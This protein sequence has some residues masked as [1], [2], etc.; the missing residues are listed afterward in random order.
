MVLSGQPVTRYKFTGVEIPAWPRL[1][2]EQIWFVKSAY[3]R[4]ELW[5][6]PRPSDGSQEKPF[7]SIADAMD[8]GKP[9]DSIRILVEH[10][11]GCGYEPF[12]VTKPGL[13]FIGGKL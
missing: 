6:W 2:P 11:E 8:R 3:G 12:T 9:G 4:G 7:V 1:R 10:M 13:T 5:E